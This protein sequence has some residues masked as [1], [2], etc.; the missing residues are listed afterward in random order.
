MV[1]QLGHNGSP[2]PSPG[3]LQTNFTVVDVSGIHQI[4]LRYCECHHVVGGSRSH[5]QLLRARWYPSTVAY[6]RNAFTFDLLDTFH[7]ITLQGKLSAY[8]FY[9]ALHHKS[10]NTG[11]WKLKVRSAAS[12]PFVHCSHDA[13]ELLHT[14]HA[15]HSNVASS[16]DSQASRPRE[17]SRWC[18]GHRPWPVCN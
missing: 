6:P 16:Q 7:L 17:R 4:N 18:C 12:A 11:L 9:N 3:A 8:D 14:I 2:C 10:D 13:I 1:L 5:I 15:R